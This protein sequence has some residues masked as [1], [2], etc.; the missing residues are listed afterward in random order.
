MAIPQYRIQAKRPLFEQIIKVL[1]M[2]GFKSLFVKML[3]K[4]FY[5]RLI[6]IERPLDKDL[7]KRALSLPVSI[8]LLGR[9]EINEYADFRPE[10]DVNEIHRRLQTGHLCFVVRHNGKIINAGWAATNKVT[11]DYLSMEFQ[12]KDDEVYGYDAFAAPAYRGSRLSLFRLTHMFKYFRDLGYQRFVGTVLLENKPAIRHILRAGSR[13][14]GIIGYVKLGPFR[15]D[16][17]RNLGKRDI[18]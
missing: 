8:G 18:F 5:R 16:F 14:Y 11:I 9:A 1:R 13:A 7:P 6:L 15:W 2:E 10:A 17:Q 3:G 4:T 12:L